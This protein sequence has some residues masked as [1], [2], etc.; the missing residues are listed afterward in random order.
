MPISITR[1]RWGVT[2]AL[3]AAT[4]LSGLAG[5]AAAADDASAATPVASAV[6]EVVVTARH[7]SENVQ[8]VPVS[9]SVISAELLK[10]TNTTNIAQLAQLVP[11]LTFSFFNARNANLNIRG[12]GNNIGLAND[13]LEP[14]VGF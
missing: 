11:S 7:R 13:G 6:G 4:A 10:K 8:K 2:A 1:G 14:G 3:L 12:L 9:V 5:T